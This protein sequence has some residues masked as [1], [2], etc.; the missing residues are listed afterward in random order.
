VVVMVSGT[1]DLLIL[2]NISVQELLVLVL[3]KMWEAEKVLDT[4]DQMILESKLEQA[5]LVVVLV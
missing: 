2:G 4:L 1:L 3:D 5:W